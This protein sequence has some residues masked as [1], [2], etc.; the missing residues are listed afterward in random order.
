MAQSVTLELPEELVNRARE[1]ADAS[2]RPVEAVLTEW[3]E[4]G[5]SNQETTFVLSGAEYHIF[6]P[7]GNE[8]AA[9]I[10]SDFL[11]AN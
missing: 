8:K 11:T 9:Q 2:H 5:A 6:T 3:L 7:Y 4:W 1:A 10:L